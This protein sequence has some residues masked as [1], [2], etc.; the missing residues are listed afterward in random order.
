M[1]TCM[2][3]NAVNIHRD[4]NAY[5]QLQG[6]LSTYYVPSTIHIS[7]WECMHKG[8]VIENKRKAFPNTHVPNKNESL[9]DCKPAG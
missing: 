2:C 3:Y 5:A 1:H 7:I 9:T 8:R 6:L 4:A